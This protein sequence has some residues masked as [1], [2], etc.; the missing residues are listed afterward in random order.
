MEITSLNRLA[1]NSSQGG[2]AILN[3]MPYD[4]RRSWIVSALYVFDP[5]RQ[6]YRRVHQHHRSPKVLEETMVAKAYRDAVGRGATCN[7]ADIKCE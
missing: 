3:T 2:P 5:A 7:S 4:T 1:C 6:V